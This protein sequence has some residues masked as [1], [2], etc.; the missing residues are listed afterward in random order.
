LSANARNKAEENY[1][2]LHRESGDCFF[3]PAEIV[4]AMKSAGLAKI[5]RRIVDTS[6][7]FSPELA[8]QDLGFAQ[9][10]FDERVEKSLGPLIE[11]HGMKYPRLQTFSGTKA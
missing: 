4:E 2:R 1:I 11:K 9:V 5:R 10:W 7:W 8:K 3:R 6:I